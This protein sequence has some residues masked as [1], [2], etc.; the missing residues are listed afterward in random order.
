MYTGRQPIV[1]W[2]V[3]QK[4]TDWSKFGN[5]CEAGNSSG[6]YSVFEC[7]RKLLMHYLQRTMLRVYLVNKSLEIFPFFS[8]PWH[9]QPSPIQSDNT[10]TA[11]SNCHC[12][13]Y[14]T[15]LTP[16]PP[17]CFSTK[18]TNYHVHNATGFYSSKGRNTLSIA[19]L[20][21]AF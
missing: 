10:G 17:K 5:R 9:H 4:G 15:M 7:T 14:V 1:N 18:I 13:L 20:L 16:P 11:P 12:S 8:W 3:A 21:H 6:L 2:V 19:L